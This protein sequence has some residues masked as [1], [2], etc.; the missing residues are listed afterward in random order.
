VRAANPQA[1]VV[2]ITG[3]RHEMDPQVERLIAEGA[4]AIQYKPLDV[5]QLLSTVRQL[6]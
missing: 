3:F 1:H 4:D 6:A 5:P 2:L